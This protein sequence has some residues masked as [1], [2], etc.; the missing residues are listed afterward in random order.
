MSEADDKSLLEL[1]KKM[2]APKIGFVINFLRWFH[3]IVGE[4]LPFR[5]CIQFFSASIRSRQLI[6]DGEIFGKKM[7]ERKRDADDA[8]KDEEGPGAHKVDSTTII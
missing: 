8:N 1:E 7:G 4:F 5:W 2:V 3:D 6:K